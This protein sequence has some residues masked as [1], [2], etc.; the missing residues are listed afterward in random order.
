MVLN[1]ATLDITA[2]VQR[3]SRF[4]LS[5]ACC[6]LQGGRMPGWSFCFTSWAITMGTGL[7]QKTVL[8]YSIKSDDC[9]I[10]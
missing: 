6:V 9:S 4:L 3:S 8:C 2:M 10:I 5:A 7:N 1:K